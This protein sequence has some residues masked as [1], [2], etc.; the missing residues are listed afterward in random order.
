MLGISLYYKNGNKAR[1]KSKC[2]QILLNLSDLYPIQKFSKIKLGVTK[3]QIIFS[4]KQLYIRKSN[5][6]KE[7]GRGADAVEFFKRALMIPIKV[8]Q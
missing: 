8:K 4:Y 1:N 3:R 5:G 6:S 7:V 2:L